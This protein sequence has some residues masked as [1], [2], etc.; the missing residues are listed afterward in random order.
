MKH[1]QMKKDKKKAAEPFLV[2]LKPEQK[3]EG[4]MSR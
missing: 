3:H 2:E 4:F 1:V